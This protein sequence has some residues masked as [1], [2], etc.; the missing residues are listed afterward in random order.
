M[1]RGPMAARDT[2]CATLAAACPANRRRDDSVPSSSRRSNSCEDGFRSRR[3]R[4]PVLPV[5]SGALRA[6][7]PGVDV[8]GVL[9]GG[10]LDTQL[11]LAVG[12]RGGHVHDERL[13][14]V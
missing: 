9:R 12:R 11:P 7:A 14:D 5:L 4:N 6:D 3:E 13:V 10:V 8:A 1:T 2:L